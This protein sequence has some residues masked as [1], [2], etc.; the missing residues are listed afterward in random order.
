L[1]LARGAD[2]LPLSSSSLFTGEEKILRQL[3]CFQGMLFVSNKNKKKVQ[4]AHS[5]SAHQFFAALLSEIFNYGEWHV[6]KIPN[7][8]PYYCCRGINF[9]VLGKIFLRLFI[10]G[11]G[12]IS[13]MESFKHVTPPTHCCKHEAGER[14]SRGLKLQ[15]K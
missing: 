7:V 15:S 11:Y 12:D 1:I 10:N 13:N 5:Q 4:D 2:G 9:D 3:I 6:W 14:L 8:A